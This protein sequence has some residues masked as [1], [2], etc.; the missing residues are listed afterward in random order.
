MLLSY[1]SYT[2]I[3]FIN[4]IITVILLCH[5]GVFISSKTLGVVSSKLKV[6]CYTYSI[7]DDNFK[8][9]IMNVT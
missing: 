6:L 1:I 7:L 2:V 4:W 8:L 9:S 5:T 3:H